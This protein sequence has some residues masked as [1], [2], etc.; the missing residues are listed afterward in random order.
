MKVGFLTVFLGNML[1]LIAADALAADIGAQFDQIVIGQKLREV[2]D[3]LGPPD[4]QIN[5]NTALVSHSQLRWAER[6]KSYVISLVFDR[7]IKTKVC[8]GAVSTC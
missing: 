1:P 4:A 3:L 6:G 7:V 8:T 2:I 5:S